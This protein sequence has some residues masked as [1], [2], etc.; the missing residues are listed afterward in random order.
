M[1]TLLLAAVGCSGRETCVAFPANHLFAVVFRGQSL[2]G[3]FNDTAAETEDE[4]EGGFLLNIVVRQRTPVLQLLPG[5]DQ[6]LL[7]RRDALLVLDLG[8]DVV[9]GVGGFDFE[10]DGFTRQG[11]D[12]DLHDCGLRC[13]CV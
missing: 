5:E 12:E 6:P 3:G 1:P 2:E 4:V 13:G 7:V 11:F 10:G 8:L 9:D